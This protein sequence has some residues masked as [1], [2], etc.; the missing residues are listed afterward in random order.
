MCG[1][2]TGP[3]AEILPFEAGNTYQKRP[4]PRGR[5]VSWVSPLGVA[6]GNFLRMVRALCPN[7]DRPEAPNDAGCRAMVLP[8]HILG[9][10]TGRR[11]SP[12][13]TL[14]GSWTS[15]RAGPQPVSG[16]R[17]R[18][19]LSFSLREPGPP[20]PP[21]PGPER[22][23]LW[24]VQILKIQPGPPGPPRLSL[25]LA[26]CPPMFAIQQLVLRP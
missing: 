7:L 21:G 2:A 18:I 9:D 17:G 12:P 6:W 23:G 22:R 5:M 11:P 26:L 15:T 3:R 10:R 19:L 13:P 24:Q 25:V 4:K 14:A 8:D 1:N 16:G 20:G